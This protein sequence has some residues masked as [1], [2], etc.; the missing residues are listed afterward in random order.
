MYSAAPVVLQN[1]SP[2]IV[3]DDVRVC[4]QCTFVATTSGAACPDAVIGRKGGRVPAF[5]GTG[6]GTDGTDG[7]DPRP[8]LAAA[9]TATP[10]PTHKPAHTNHTSR[11]NRRRVV[12]R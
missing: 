10:A 2:F 12:A 4:P 8:L 5:G 9:C 6:F 3:T 7:A 11:A 1:R